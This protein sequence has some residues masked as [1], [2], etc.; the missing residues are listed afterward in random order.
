MIVAG[1][2]LIVLMTFAG[3]M[4]AA[5]DGKVDLEVGDPSPEFSLQ[6][7]DGKTHALKDYAGTRPMVIAWFPK[8]FTSG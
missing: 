2:V 1:L 3:R 5:A 8:A 7:S 6:G 4:P